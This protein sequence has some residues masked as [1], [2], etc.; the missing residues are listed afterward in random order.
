LL[1]IP[2]VA[3]AT[4][5]KGISAVNEGLPPGVGG[6]MVV[7]VLA[8]AISGYAAIVFLLKLVRTTSYRPFVIYR[9]A[10]GIAV[11]L[12]IALGLR[13]ATF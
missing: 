11:L 1:L 5:F 3:G 4:L 8:S 12:V 13:P 10:A 2:V 6:P 9:Y 7:G